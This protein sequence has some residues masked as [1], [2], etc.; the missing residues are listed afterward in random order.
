MTGDGDAGDAASPEEMQR[1]MGYLYRRCS[2]SRWICI[3]LKGLKLKIVK[4]N[5]DQKMTGDGNREQISYRCSN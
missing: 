2:I 4:K 1:E 5:F 3:S